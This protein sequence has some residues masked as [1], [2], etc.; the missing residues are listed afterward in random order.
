MRPVLLYLTVVLLLSGTAL[1]HGHWTDRWTERYD[2]EAI[3]QTLERLPAAIGAWD[4]QSN[5]VEDAT[6]RQLMKGSHLLPHHVSRVNATAVTRF[7]T[8]H[9]QHTLL[10]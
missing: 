8:A 7:L 10:E 3:T 9:P 6:L 2:P 5:E 1:L 4:A